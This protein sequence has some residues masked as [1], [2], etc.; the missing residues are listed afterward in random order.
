MVANMRAIKQAILVCIAGVSWAALPCSAH[1][2]E[3]Q[4]QLTML[5]NETGAVEVV[6]RWSGLKQEA[7]V[8]EYFSAAREIGIIPV[9]VR[10][11]GFTINFTTRSYLRYEDGIYHFVT[12][13]FYYEDGPLDVELALTYPPNLV[14]L[15]A[16]PPPDYEGDGV[17]HWSIA[18]ASHQ[19]VMARFERIGPFVMPGRTGP[20]WQVDPAALT[21]LRAEEL[22]AS[23]DEVLKELENIINIARASQATDADFLTVM[24]KLLAKFYYILSINGLVLD[25]VYPAAESAEE[26]ETAPAGDSAEPAGTLST[27]GGAAARGEG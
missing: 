8:F 1:A 24:D 13:D 26:E 16:D 18:D 6:D 25:Y 21:Q 14:L 19:I 5:I 15:G 20:D 11:F 22:P 17:L 12:P 9:T 2:A 7:G 23:A 3:T 10:N 27:G 4:S